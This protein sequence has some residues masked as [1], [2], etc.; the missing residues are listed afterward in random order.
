MNGCLLHLANGTAVSEEQFSHEARALG[1]L[2]ICILLQGGRKNGKESGR[3]GSQPRN[4]KILLPVSLSIF[5]ELSHHDDGFHTESLV[6]AE[7]LI[8]FRPFSSQQPSKVGFA[9]SSV[10]RRG[11]SN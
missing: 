3:R 5:T 10:Q 9:S 11:L 7:Y 1:H 6:H 2:G 8:A 4:H